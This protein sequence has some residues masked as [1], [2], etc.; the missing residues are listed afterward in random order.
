MKNI[1]VYWLT[2]VS[3][4]AAVVA[5]AT[6]IVV[7]TDEQLVRKTPLIVVGMVA[8]SGPIDRGNGIWTETHLIVEQTLK[9]MAIRAQEKGIELVCD[10]RPEV[11]DWVIADPTRI[12]QILINLVGNAVKFTTEGEVSVTLSRVQ[13]RDSVDAGGR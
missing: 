7:P 6:T 13:N 8:S 1:R 12:R 11:P 4:L 5:S 3:M 9:G 2:C 10:V